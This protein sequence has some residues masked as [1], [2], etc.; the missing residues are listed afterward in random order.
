MNEGLHFLLFSFLGGLAAL[1]LSPIFIPLFENWLEHLPANRRKREIRAQESEKYAEAVIEAM[2]I[3]A[4][5]LA[6]LEGKRTT[7]QDVLVQEEK[8][9]PHGVAQSN[10]GNRARGQRRAASLMRAA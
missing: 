3:R 9:A 4:R 8:I 10:R 5:I 7:P 6:E 1:A 2:Q